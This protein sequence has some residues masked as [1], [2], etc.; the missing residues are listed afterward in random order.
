MSRLVELQRRAYA[1]ESTPEERASAEAELA[2]LRETKVADEPFGIPSW[3]ASRAPRLLLALLLGASVGTGLVA[4]VNATFVPPATALEV[5]DR[6]ATAQ[7][8]GAP[9]WAFVGGASQVRLI[10]VVRQRQVFAY[11]NDAGEVCIALV[12]GALANGTCT[13]AEQFARSGLTLTSY[14]REAMQRINRVVVT[15]GPDGA[16]TVDADVVTAP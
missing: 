15:W 7:D 3:S 1:R 12:D 6:A 8:A 5:F 14:D 16:I 2:A 9:R 11:L 4:T 10:A 13:S